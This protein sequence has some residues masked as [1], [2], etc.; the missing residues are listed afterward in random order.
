[1][2]SFISHISGRIAL[3]NLSPV[4][5]V[6]KMISPYANMHQSHCANVSFGYSVS[7]V[8]GPS[9]MSHHMAFN[10]HGYLSVQ[11]LTAILLELPIS[12]VEGADLAGFQPAGDAVEMES[13]V[14]DSPC[15]SAFL[16][17]GRSLVCLAF[18][19]QV[20]NMVSADGTVV[21]DDVPSPKSYCIPLLHLKA[22]LAISSALGSSSFG[23]T[24]WLLSWGWNVC[25]N[26]VGHLEI[27]KLG[28]VRR[29]SW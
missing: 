13:M 6:T 4:N 25:H 14:A 15:Y 29:G 22:L 20:H 9:F 5:A 8:R 10:C 1:M 21:D 27:A 18:D 17:G 26:D 28:T 24:N 23:L 3:Q 7:S 19:A 16:T 11:I 12:V 2:V